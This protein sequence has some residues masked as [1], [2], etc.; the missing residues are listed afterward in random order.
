VAWSGAGLAT[1]MLAVGCTSNRERMPSWGIPGAGGPGLEVRF[2]T[3]PAEG[4]QDY[5]PTGQIDSWSRLVWAPLPQTPPEKIIG[6]RQ[7]NHT[8]HTLFP[9]RY[10]FE[11]LVPHRQDQL[12]YGELCVYGPASFWAQDFLRHTF[13]LVNPGAGMSASGHPSILTEDDLQRV[14]AGD[15]V[16]KVV[17][18]ADLKAVQGRIAMIDQE[19]RRLR[20]EEARLAAQEEYWGVKTADR[21]RNALY[22]GDYGEDIPAL[23]LAMYQLLIGPETYHWRRYSEAEDR[24][25]TYQEKIASLQ[26]PMD[27]LREERGALRA[28]QGSIKILHR[29]G[30]LVLATPSM[31][32]RYR[33]PVNEVTEFRRTLHGPDMGLDAPY[34]FSEVAHTVHWPHPFSVAGIYPRLIETNNRM[35]TY[36]EPVGEVLLVMRVGPREPHSLK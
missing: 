13:L 25:R 9:G 14:I 16:T 17:F 28:L 31:T 1:L 23:H 3:P 29:R 19:L 35:G 4:P 8:C 20:D 18:V 5:Q 32:R 24:M 21:R 33:D 22:F 30:D 7:G 11:Y 27:R 15:V 2:Y 12:L 6:V 10:E 34:W 36:H 26:L